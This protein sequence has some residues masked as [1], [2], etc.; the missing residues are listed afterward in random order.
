MML[1]QTLISEYGTMY[2]GVAHN[3]N[4]HRTLPAAVFVDRAEAL[5]VG[6]AHLDAAVRLPVVARNGLLPYNQRPAVLGCGTVEL[7]WHVRDSFSQG[8]GRLDCIGMS[9][10][11]FP[12]GH[13]NR[14]RILLP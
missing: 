2:Q 1:H 9:E 10:I 11:Y 4:R 7:H 6:V 5:H 8:V 13:V 14:L 12:A 3:R